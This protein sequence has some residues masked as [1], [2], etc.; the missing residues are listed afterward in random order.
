MLLDLI[1]HDWYWYQFQECLV[2]LWMVNGNGNHLEVKVLVLSSWNA[3]WISCMMKIRWGGL[4]Q[5][6]VFSCHSTWEAI[7]VRSGEVDWWKLVWNTIFISKKGFILWLAIKNRLCTC[8]RMTAWGRHG[9]V[10]CVFCRSREQFR[11]H[12]FYDLNVGQYAMIEC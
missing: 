3:C 9:S 11:D 1:D 10:L 2:L 4:I 8:D 5:E 6:V 7:R 12:L